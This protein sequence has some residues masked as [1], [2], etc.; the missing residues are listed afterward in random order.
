MLQP[1]RN[2]RFKLRDDQVELAESLRQI[3]GFET[4]GSVVNHVFAVYAPAALE[5]IKK[6]QKSQRSLPHSTPSV[7]ETPLVSSQQPSISEP[8]PIAETAP[9]APP[10]LG[11][12]GDSM[13]RIRQ[14]LT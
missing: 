6:Q 13:K 9:P 12:F 3:G 11:G 8:D 2:T 4:L 7:P 1:Q 10:P 14:K 5:N